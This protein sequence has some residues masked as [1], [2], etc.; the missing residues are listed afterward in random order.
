L[1]YSGR[2]KDFVR[3]FKDVYDPA[4]SRGGFIHLVYPEYGK[5]HSKIKP[6]KEFVEEKLKQY[7][8]AI[9]LLG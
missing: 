2:G 5:N 1:L 9:W 6:L 7:S 8:D 4:E 3:L